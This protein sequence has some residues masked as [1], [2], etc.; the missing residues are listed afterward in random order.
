MQPALLIRFRIVLGIFIGGLVLSGVTAFPLSHELDLMA[1]ML[2]VDQFTPQSAPHDLGRWVL[3]VRDG[4]REMYAAH[5]WIAYGTDWLAFAHLVLAV[6]FISP[7]R[8]PVR[9]VWVLQAGII[10]CV[11][12]LPLALICGPLRGIPLYW[13][14]VD[15]SFGVF[16][17]LP[18]MYCLSLARRMELTTPSE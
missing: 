10:A 7:W 12:V 9:N 2:G 3:T 8:D 16:G 17:A 6:F 5:P 1:R 15:C 4:L 13:R 18:L 14:L 11:L